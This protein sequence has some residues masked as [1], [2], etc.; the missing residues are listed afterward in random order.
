MNI[1]IDYTSTSFGTSNSFDFSSVAYG[2]FTG[3]IAK[4]P[5]E[6]LYFSY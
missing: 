2:Q 4:R 1:P 3:V 6:I 5:K